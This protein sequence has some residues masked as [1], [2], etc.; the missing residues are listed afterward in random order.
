MYY[1]VT[2][3]RRHNIIQ[4]NI[5]DTYRITHG[6]SQMLKCVHDCHCNKSCVQKL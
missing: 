1:Y 4:H 6:F 5:L 2:L 3:S